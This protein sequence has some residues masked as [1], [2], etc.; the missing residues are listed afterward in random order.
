VDNPQYAD[1][2]HIRTWVWQP[3]TGLVQHNIDKRQKYD[4]VCRWGWDDAAKKHCST[5]TGQWSSWCRRWSVTQSV[6]SVL[7]C[8]HRSH[9]CY[10]QYNT[11]WWSI[12]ARGWTSTIQ[13][14]NNIQHTIQSFFPIL[15]LR[16]F[17]I[18]QLAHFRI[19]FTTLDAWNNYFHILLL[20][21]LITREI[22]H[23][24]TEKIFCP[25]LPF[26]SFMFP[27]TTKKHTLIL[28]IC[29]TITHQ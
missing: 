1:S 20:W 27:V 19:I 5:D 11:V 25:W 10:M 4:M 18:L 2:L 14:N 12:T 24:N 23:C 9:Y 16:I 13:Y 21:T 26:Q 6:Y 28:Y 17:F 8:L 15:Y 22:C 29:R 7:S 3:K